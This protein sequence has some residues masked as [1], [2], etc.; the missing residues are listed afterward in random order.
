MARFALVSRFVNRFKSLMLSAG[1]LSKMLK[2]FMSGAWQAGWPI[3][4][5]QNPTISKVLNVAGSQPWENP[6]ESAL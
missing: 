6:A 1:T 2:E 4:A 3:S 5:E